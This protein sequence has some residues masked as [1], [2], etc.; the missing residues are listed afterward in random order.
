[1]LQIVQFQQIDCDAEQRFPAPIVV[2]A[3]KMIQ[4]VSLPLQLC[5]VEF[6]AQFPE[7]FY[8]LLLMAM[9]D[10]GVKTVYV[11]ISFAGIVTALETILPSLLFQ[12]AS[13]YSV[14]EKC[15]PSDVRHS[16]WEICAK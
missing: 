6:F 1:M 10:K 4:Q 3:Q 13:C 5:R 12:T 14:F 15:F 7:F 2:S 16:L 8:I 11:V 9:R